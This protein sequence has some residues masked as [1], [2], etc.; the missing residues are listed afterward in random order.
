MPC[1]RTDHM[2]YNLGTAMSF[3]ISGGNGHSPSPLSRSLSHLDVDM[4]VFQGRGHAAG[5]HGPVR[6]ALLGGVGHSHVD[7]GGQVARAASRNALGE[8]AVVPARLACAGKRR[9]AKTKIAEQN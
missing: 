2:Y 8:A 4:V 5:A 3:F 7:V 9:A 6:P 1:L